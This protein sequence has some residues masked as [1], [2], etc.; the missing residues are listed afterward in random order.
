MNAMKINEKAATSLLSPQR[1]VHLPDTDSS[2][3]FATLDMEELACTALFSVAA[4]WKV[5]RTLLG[6]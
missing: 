5:G 1:V 3:L 6:A 4:A 2:E